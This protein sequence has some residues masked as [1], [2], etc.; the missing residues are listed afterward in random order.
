MANLL[1]Q[2]ESQESASTMS[3]AGD[4]VPNKPRT[5]IETGKSFELGNVS[6]L[7]L[8]ATGCGINATV[9]KIQKQIPI[10]LQ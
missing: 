8:A 10:F 5:C 1:S 2:P 3:D 6:Y 7:N 4:H 9:P